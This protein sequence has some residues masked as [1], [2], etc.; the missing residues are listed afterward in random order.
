MANSNFQQLLDCGQ[1]LWMDYLSRQAIESGD[2]KK[3]HRKPG[4]KRNYL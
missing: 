2:L 4:I 1:S 3:T